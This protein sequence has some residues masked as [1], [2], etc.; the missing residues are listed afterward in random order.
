MPFRS[1][2]KRTA[3]QE[4]AIEFHWSTEHLARRPHLAHTDGAGVRRAARLTRVALHRF[5]RYQLLRP[6]SIPR[7]QPDMAKD[8]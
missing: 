8:C 4:N 7:R 3:H 5:G 2:T 6:S 1:A